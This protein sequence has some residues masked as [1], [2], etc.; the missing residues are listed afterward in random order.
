MA[1]R[2][3]CSRLAS[4]LSGGGEGGAGRGPGAGGAGRGDGR[5]GAVGL[6]G[7]ASRRIHAGAGRIWHGGRAGGVRGRQVEAAAKQHA[8]LES[9]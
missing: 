6:R 1:R 9:M 7:G 2:S 3:H 8:I 5:G 4:G